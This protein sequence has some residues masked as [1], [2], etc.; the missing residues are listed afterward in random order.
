MAVVKRAADEMVM[1]K[2]VQ[3]GKR[4]WQTIS[5]SFACMSFGWFARVHPITR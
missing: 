2:S 4:K 3:L 1:K 5:V